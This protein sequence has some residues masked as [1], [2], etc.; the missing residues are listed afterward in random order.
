MIA[1]VERVLSLLDVAKAPGA[2]DLPGYRLHRLKGE[3]QG[4]WSIAVNANWRI[5]FRFD[6][7]DAC[8]VE[9]IDYH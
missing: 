9:L 7:E 2:L 5:V 8:D 1:R 3:W 4:F 6:G